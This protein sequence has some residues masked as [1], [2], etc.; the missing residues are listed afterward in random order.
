[1]SN[2]NL[3]DVA[4]ENMKA[5]MDAYVHID[6]TESVKVEVDG[7]TIGLDR[8]ADA[9]TITLTTIYSVDEADIGETE[10]SVD[11]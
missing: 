10:E 8:D 7:L 2:N 6:M 4:K 9:G 5:I 3:I 11:D 1:M